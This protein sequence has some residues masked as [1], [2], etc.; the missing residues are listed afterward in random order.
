MDNDHVEQITHDAIGF[1]RL[2]D[3]FNEF[4]DWHTRERIEYF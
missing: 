2:K 3:G 4:F 1:Q